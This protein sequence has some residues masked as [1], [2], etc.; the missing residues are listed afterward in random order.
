[1]VGPDDVKPFVFYYLC[2]RNVL[3]PDQADPKGLQEGLYD[4]VKVGIMLF[5]CGEDLCR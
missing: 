2:F 3:N 4:A 1:M 5:F